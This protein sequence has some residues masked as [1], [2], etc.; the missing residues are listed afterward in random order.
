MSTRPPDPSA[1][2][3][4][5]VEVAGVGP[6]RYTTLLRSVRGMY[7]LHVTR[8]A[9]FALVFF[10]PG[11]VLTA[12]VHELIEDQQAAI[13]G[14]IGAGLAMLAV[15]AR[16]LSLLG[17][18]LFAGFL[19]AAVG[20]EH[21]GEGRRTV[22]E[23]LRT[24]P[25]GRLVVADIVLVT[26]TMVTAAFFVIPSLVVYS[27]FC[28]VG[29]LVNMRGHVVL[30][31]FSESFR[32]VRPHFVLV[33]VAVTLPTAFEVA[34]HHAFEVILHDAA[35]V[36]VTVVNWLLIASVFTVVG[37]FEVAL[38]YELVARDEPGWREDGTHDR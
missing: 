1:P 28:L 26:A 24:L 6:L 10:L 38:A 11:V 4:G 8:I 30:K 25:W 23:V 34:A 33:F 2:D 14:V 31:A 20:S 18:V 3:A 12:Q 37:L 32:L 22:G 19:E 13:G 9:G 15:V 16:G 5:G 17:P 35:V 27:L 36:V 7:R 29:P 21:Y